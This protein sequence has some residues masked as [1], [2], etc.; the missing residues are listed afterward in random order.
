MGSLVSNVWNDRAAA[1]PGRSRCLS[2]PWYGYGL[3]LL[4]QNL[5]EVAGQRVL[6]IGC[7]VGELIELLGDLGFT[8]VGVDGNAEQVDAVKRRGLE[9]IATDLERGLPFADRSFDGATCLEVIEH[10]ARAERLLQETGRI[11]K[12]GGFLLLS[13]PNYGYLHHRAHHL[14]GRPPWNEGVHLRFFTAASL[15]TAL[16]RAG[17]EVV[18]QSSFGPI[19]LWSTVATRILRRS[20]PLW[21]VPR[22][23]EGLLAYTLV[24]LARR[25]SPR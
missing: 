11:L 19:P 20:H 17:F 12:V 3:D 16:A 4:Q 24:F 2:R 5:S 8:A 18:A 13:T 21:R 15:R 25:R 7:G 1:G 10:I 6:D 9:A 22:R 14:L 23:W